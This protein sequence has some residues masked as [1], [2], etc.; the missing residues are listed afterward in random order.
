MAAATLFVPP[1]KDDGNGRAPD[2]AEAKL[3]AALV[4][5]GAQMAKSDGQ[6]RHGDILAFR[7]V[8]RTDSQT[9]AAI[10]RFLNFAR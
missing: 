10:A 8:F 4:A 6:V 9:H 2:V 3:V 1:N 7:Q 5:L